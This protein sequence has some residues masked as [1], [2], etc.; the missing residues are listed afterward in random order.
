M[1]ADIPH[2]VSICPAYDTPG[3]LS[4]ASH[5]GGG[6]DEADIHPKLKEFKQKQREVRCA[7][8]LAEK[9]QVL[10]DSGEEE[11][12]RRAHEEANELGQSA[13][14]GTLLNVIGTTYVEQVRKLCY[15]LVSWPALDWAM[16]MFY[17]LTAMQNPLFAR[18]SCVLILY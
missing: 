9:L 7:V 17:S 16:P 2:H 5:M 12:S 11:F 3:E 1:I 15:A 8:H 10:L 13:F 14:G 4:I 18:R 6:D